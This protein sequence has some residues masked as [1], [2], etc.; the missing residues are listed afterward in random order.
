MKTFGEIKPKD[1]IY[2]YEKKPRKSIRFVTRYDVIEINDLTE[3]VVKITF[4]EFADNL[5]FDYVYCLKENFAM[6]YRRTSSK[7]K[8]ILSPNLSETLL[9]DL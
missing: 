5:P 2:L 1:F 9:T 7:G 6:P 8:Y 3:D 4:G